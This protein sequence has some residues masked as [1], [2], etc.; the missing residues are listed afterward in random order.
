M[1]LLFKGWNFLYP[2]ETI[3]K[4]CRFNFYDFR[5]LF[6]PTVAPF[7]PCKLPFIV[8]PPFPFGE[9]SFMNGPLIVITIELGINDNYYISF[10]LQ[11]K[12]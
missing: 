10:F 8:A 6:P 9:T 11:K 1:I 3:H 2:L 12:F 7:T 5:P 4:T